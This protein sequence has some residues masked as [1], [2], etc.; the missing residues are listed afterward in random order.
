M[1]TWHVLLC[2][3]LS[4]TARASKIF[5]AAPP[6]PD[7]LMDDKGG[8]S[9]VGPVQEGLRWEV[10]Q[11]LAERIACHNR[12]YAEYAGYWTAE[13]TFLAEAEGAD[14]IE[15]FDS[16]TGKLLFVAPRG[17]TMEAFLE[18]SRHHGWPS[19]REEETI[20]NTTPS[21]SETRHS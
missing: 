19:F 14:E 16:V 20:I 18:E 3:Q 5:G 6:G 7:S 21:R 2:M 11:E 10:D 15:F 1:R 8:T 13:T 9:C 17:R 12:R 4:S